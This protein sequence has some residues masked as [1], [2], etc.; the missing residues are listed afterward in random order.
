[1]SFWDIV[2]FIV[3]A[4]AF[5]AYL[6]VM[7]SVITD[8]FRDRTQSGAAKAVW[9]VGLIVIPFFT[10]LVYLIARGS[11]M[12]ERSQRD[13]RAAQAAQEDYIRSVVGAESPVDQ[14]AHARALLD[15]GAVTAAEYEQ[16]KAK[17]LA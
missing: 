14:I 10:S 8:L 16:L 3:I 9:V 11:G 17:A 5:I 15:A 12:A 1:M 6:M 2:W 13:L 7:F 4:F